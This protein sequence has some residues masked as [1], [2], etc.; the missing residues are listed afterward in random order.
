MFL[1]NLHVFS[2]AY[3]V[4]IWLRSFYGGYFTFILIVNS[5]KIVE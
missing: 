4:N 1:D 5:G 2:F 3:F